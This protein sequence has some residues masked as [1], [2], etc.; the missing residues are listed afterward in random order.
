[1]SSKE[2]EFDEKF[3]LE[4]FH[5]SIP[6]FQVACTY[7]YESKTASVYTFRVQLFLTQLNNEDIDES[8]TVEISV[9]ED[10]SSNNEDGEEEEESS[11]EELD[12]EYEGNQEEEGESDESPEDDAEMESQE[13]SENDG[14]CEEET[15]DASEYNDRPS[16]VWGSVQ[17]GDKI[18]L[19]ESH[20]LNA[21]NSEE[22]PAYL[23]V[24]GKWTPTKVNFVFWI[25]FET[26]SR[27]EK[28]ALK[29]ITNV[30]V[31][32]T[33][34]DVQFCFEEDQQ[35]GGHTTILTARSP[36]FAAMFQNNMSESHTGRVTITDIKPEIFKELLHFIYSGRTLTALTEDTAQSLFVLADKYDIEDLKES[37]V[38]YLL[39]T[40]RVDN[41]INLMAWAHLHSVDKLKEATL[42]FSAENGQEI[43]ELDDWEQLMKNYPD[44]CLLVTRRMMRSCSSL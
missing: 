28:K 19:K 16:A 37:C 2:G 35:I 13:T 40:V 12:Y 3:R 22:F 1:M 10:G 9:Q 30:F 41:A 7:N 36:V 4:Q 15:A 8:N 17:G 14:S 11:T 29:Q 44:I 20:C 27:S 43:V 5:P 39:S 18:L 38:R 25:K 23:F 42:D 6:H 24:S 32:Q 26:F 31:Q 21:W 33:N 34:C